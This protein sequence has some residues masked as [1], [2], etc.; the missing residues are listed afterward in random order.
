MVK[1]VKE[2]SLRENEPGK[3]L[4]YYNE[5]FKDVFVFKSGYPEDSVWN[6]RKAY[7]EAEKYAILLE[8]NNGMLTTKE[9]IF[10]VDSSLE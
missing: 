8:K 2:T 7:I 10:V 4:I 1:I 9:T 6:E 5:D 3:F